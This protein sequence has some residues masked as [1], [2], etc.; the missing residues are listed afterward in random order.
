M[1]LD[2]VTIGV[3]GVQAFALIVLTVNGVI[4][5]IK[6]QSERTWLRE[7]IREV[8]D[9]NR[10]SQEELKD[11]HNKVMDDVIPALAGVTAVLPAV[12]ERLRGDR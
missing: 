5:R 1:S 4:D 8:E 10:S 6:N 2:P 12:L 9:Y 11:L 3:T 7:R